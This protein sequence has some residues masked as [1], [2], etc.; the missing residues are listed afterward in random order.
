MNNHKNSRLELDFYFQF[1][2]EK[3]YNKSP[4]KFILISFTIIFYL[5]IPGFHISSLEISR[6][7]I[8]G[9]MEQRAF[10]NFLIY[11]PYQYWL[12]YNEIPDNFKRAIIVMEDDGFV[13]HKGIDWESLQLASRI[14]LRRGKIVRGGSTITMQ[15][16]KNIYFTTHRNYFRKAKEILTAMRMEKELEKK[17]ILEHYLNIIELGDG[18]FGI[19][20]ASKKYFNKEAAELTKEQIARIVA[21]VPSPLRH[22]PVGNSGFVIRRK[23][24]ALSRMFLAIIPDKNDN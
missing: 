21:I 14:N 1:I 20:A 15:T 4:F 22:S 23:N 2:K 6:T 3:F 9:V 11:Y 17:T 7:R 10:Q 24:I 16:A 19:Q 18:I 8:S 5:A 12:N 13:F